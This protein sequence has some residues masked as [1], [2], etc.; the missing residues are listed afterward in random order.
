MWPALLFNSY[1]DLASAVFALFNIVKSNLY[2]KD[3]LICEKSYVFLMS[4]I[5]TTVYDVLKE[6]KV[7]RALLINLFVITTSVSPGFPFFD[8]L[9]FIENSG[10]LFT[11]HNPKVFDENLTLMKYS[12]SNGILK[13]FPRISHNAMHFTFFFKLSP[14]EFLWYVVPLGVR[15]DGVNPQNSNGRNPFSAI[16]VVYFLYIAVYCT[17]S[18]KHCDK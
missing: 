18:I 11:I 9:L 17:V 2:I 6:N 12:M 15:S 10:R 3:K 8:S 14:L 16:F 7:R 5:K 4:S 1:N 13:N